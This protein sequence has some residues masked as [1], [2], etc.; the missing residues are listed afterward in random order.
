MKELLFDPAAEA[1]PSCYRTNSYHLSNLDQTA[2]GLLVIMANTGGGLEMP[3][4]IDT[5]T[6]T[7]TSYT[8][9]SHHERRSTQGEMDAIQ[10]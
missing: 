9:G 7:S 1:A 6:E 5:D 2:A 10:R 8:G 4:Q 3:G